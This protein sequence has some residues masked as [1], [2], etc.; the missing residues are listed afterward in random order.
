VDGL[1]VGAP[2]V[3]AGA[4]LDAGAAESFSGTAGGLEVAGTWLQQSRPESGDRFGSAVFAGDLSVVDANAELVVGAPGEDVM[5]AADAGQVSVYEISELGVYPVPVTIDERR[6]GWRLQAGGGF[7]SSL[8][9]GLLFSDNDE[10][11]LVVGAPGHD[12]RTLPDAGAVFI[13]S[14]NNGHPPWGES[15]VVRGEQAGEELGA[16]LAMVKRSTSLPGYLAVGSPGANVAGQD[17]AGRVR[18]Y[19]GDALT[20]VIDEST[21]GGPVGA[22][23][24]FGAGLA[25]GNLVGSTVSAQIAVAAPGADGGAGRVGISAVDLDEGTF[26][27]EADVG[28]APEPGD[29]FG[30]LEY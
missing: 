11:E 13:V 8:A 3:D 25:P 5:G 1:L 4:A 24:R 20:Q 14:A 12:N 26:L 30:R 23:D 10:P 19:R 29:G 2:G 27:D 18:V 15:A 16:A 17:D 7:G 22:G 28:G 9:T 6:F 21:W